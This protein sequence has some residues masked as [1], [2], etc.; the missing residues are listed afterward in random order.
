MRGFLHAPA[1]HYSGYCNWFEALDTDS[2]HRSAKSDIVLSSARYGHVNNR[3]CAV[4]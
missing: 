4:V 1:S 2:V 3:A